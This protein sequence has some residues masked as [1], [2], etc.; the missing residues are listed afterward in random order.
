[1]LYHGVSRSQASLKLRLRS[2]STGPWQDISMQVQGP[3]L[4]DLSRN[5]S[6]AWDLE[7]PWYKRWFSTPSLTA[8][9]VSLP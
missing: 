5:F 3:V 6:E 9:R 2:S 8:E 1:R 7:T 4:A